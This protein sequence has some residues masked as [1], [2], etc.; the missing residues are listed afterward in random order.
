MLASVN[1]LHACRLPKGD[2]TVAEYWF[3]TPDPYDSAKMRRILTLQGVRN[4]WFCGA[5]FG[6]GFHEDAL[7]A[8]LAVAEQLG[9]VRRPWSVADE[10]GRIYL[11]FP[12]PQGEGV[13]AARSGAMTGGAEAR[14][15]QTHSPSAPHPSRHATR[16]ATPSPSGREV[17]AA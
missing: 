9:G 2:G 13:I 15:L 17:P 8:G 4:T 16:D 3:R 12:S 5:H 11:N 14:P 10:S 7:Q 1:D 6:A